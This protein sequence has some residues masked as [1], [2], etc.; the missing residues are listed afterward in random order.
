LYFLPSLY[1]AA[2]CASSR[3]NTQSMRVVVSEEVTRMG[4]RLGDF[5]KSSRL[6]RTLFQEAFVAIDVRFIQA[7]ADQP[8]QPSQVESQVP[9]ML[10][11]VGLKTTGAV[12]STAP[13]SS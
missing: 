1:H 11:T 4:P 10:V 2:V 3:D 13:V 5:G 6:P 9:S 12:E 8:N 7:N